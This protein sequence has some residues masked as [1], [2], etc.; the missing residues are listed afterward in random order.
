MLSSRAAKSLLSLLASHGLKDAPSGK[1]VRL[2]CG[3]FMPLTIERIGAG[4]R[5]LTAFSICH[6]G[7]QNGDSMRDPEV[8]FEV[9]DDV[10]SPYSV[11]MDYT[12]YSREVIWKDENGREMI[13]VKEYN[14][15]LSFFAQWIRNIRAQGFFEPDKVDVLG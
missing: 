11:R 8:R 1:G 9:R 2:H 6:Y 4:P 10:V 3:G 13:C 7:K 15:L 5:G 12:G 14:D